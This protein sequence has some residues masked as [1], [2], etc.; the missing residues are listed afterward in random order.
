MGGSGQPVL[1]IAH[2][3]QRFCFDADGQQVDC[4][5]ESAAIRVKVKAVKAPPQNKAVLS[6][7]DDKTGKTKRTNKK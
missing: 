7:P 5:D 3:K 4:E 2:T 1:V 6:P